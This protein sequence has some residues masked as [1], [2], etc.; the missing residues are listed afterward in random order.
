[1]P[2][3][4][5]FFLIMGAFTGV[6]VATWM[7]AQ[8]VPKLGF[9]AVPVHWDATMNRVADGVSFVLLSGITWVA[10]RFVL[11]SM[12]SGQ[13]ASGGLHVPVW[14]IQLA[15]PVGFGSA[16]IRYLAFALWPGVRPEA[17]DTLE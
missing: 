10:S 16:A 11:E 4:V 12:G 3:C 6:G 9:R 2:S 17:G 5:V 7:G 15:I 13:M 8:L 1:M 14:Q